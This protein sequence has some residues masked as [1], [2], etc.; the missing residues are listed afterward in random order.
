VYTS[1]LD[2]VRQKIGVDVDKLNNNPSDAGKYYV[3]RVRGIISD[4]WTL[5]VVILI[6]FE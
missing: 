5:Y 3:W 2:I 4:L 1:V 6:F